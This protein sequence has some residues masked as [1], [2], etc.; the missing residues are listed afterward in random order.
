[1]TSVH[2]IDYKI[3][4]AMQREKLDVGER[5]YANLMISSGICSLDFKALNAF[6]SILRTVDI[7]YI[8]CVYTL[9]TTFVTCMI[10]SLDIFKI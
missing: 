7:A 3:T 2:A 8:K 6:R 4:H 10:V 9:G 1:M 5:R